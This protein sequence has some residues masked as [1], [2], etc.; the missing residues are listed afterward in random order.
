MDASQSD[1]GKDVDRP[2]AGRVAG[3]GP[4]GEQVAGGADR[5]VVVECLHD[6]D[7]GPPRLD[8]DRRRDLP[9]DAV[10][11]HDVGPEV[12]EEAAEPAGG[13]DVPEHPPGRHRLLAPPQSRV[14]A[15]LEVRGEVVRPGRRVVLRMPRREVRDLVAGVLEPGDLVE[16]DA[17]G[18][19]PPVPELVRHQDAHAGSALLRRRPHGRRL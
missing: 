3:R 15:D 9:V 10:D 4:A 16:H 7:A 6:G 14:R 8:Q 19:G 12:A 11:V 5:V 18:A 17:F 1:A 2:A 13:R